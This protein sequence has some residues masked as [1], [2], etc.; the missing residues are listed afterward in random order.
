LFHY[1]FLFSFL[2]FFFLPSLYVPSRYVSVSV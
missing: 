2:K 1:L